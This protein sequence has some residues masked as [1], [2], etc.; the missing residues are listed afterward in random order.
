M[1]KFKCNTDWSILDLEDTHFISEENTKAPLL[2]TELPNEVE[3]YITNW[4]TVW[5]HTQ[6]GTPVI[7]LEINQALRLAQITVKVDRVMNQTSNWVDISPTT[8]NV[9]P[10][11]Y[12]PPFTL[13]QLAYSTDTWVEINANTCT[14]RCKTS[15]ASSTSKKLRTVFTYR[16]KNLNAPFN[17]EPEPEPTPSS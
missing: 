10:S 13:R 12:L 1:V 3:A 17:P 2:E 4:K 9:F 11:E 6:Q 5:Q 14:L 8:T 16:Y 15:N 7:S